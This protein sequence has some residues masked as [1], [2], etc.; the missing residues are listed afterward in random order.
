MLI[1][2]R[3]LPTKLTIYL[4]YFFSHI[5]PSQEDLVESAV[6]MASQIAEKSPVAVAGTKENLIYARDHSVE[7]GLKHVVCTPTLFNKNL[8]GYLYFHS[9]YFQRPTFSSIPLFMNQS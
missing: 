4:V 6:S 7:D 9:S 3:L 1:Y 5:F 8:Y 2:V